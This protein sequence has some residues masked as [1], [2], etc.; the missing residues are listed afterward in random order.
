MSSA[1]ESGHLGARF[2]MLA[3]S[4]AQRE[5]YHPRSTLGHHQTSASGRRQ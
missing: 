2:E 4:S 5:S 3:F 1:A